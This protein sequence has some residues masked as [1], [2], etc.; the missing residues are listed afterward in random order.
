MNHRPGIPV[1]FLCMPHLNGV[2]GESHKH[3]RSFSLGVP[4]AKRLADHALEPWRYRERHDEA[5]AEL[6]RRGGNH[7]SPCFQPAFFGASWEEWFHVADADYNLMKLANLC[8]DCR[9][10]ILRRKSFW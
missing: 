7:R 10:M 5:A 4:L 8:W 1:K 6:L 3:Y 9:Q 2:H